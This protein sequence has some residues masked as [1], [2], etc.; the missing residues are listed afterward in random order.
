MTGHIDLNIP[1]HLFYWI[2]GGETQFWIASLL[3]RYK[4]IADGC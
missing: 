4:P 2:Y 3:I 1:T